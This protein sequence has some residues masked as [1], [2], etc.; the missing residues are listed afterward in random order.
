M[1]GA[2]NSNGR[3]GLSVGIPYSTVSSMFL[4][5]FVHIFVEAF[6]TCFAMHALLVWFSIIIGYQDFV[7]WKTTQRLIQMNT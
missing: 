4:I 2:M 7:D 6:H 3:Y 1:Y 5:F